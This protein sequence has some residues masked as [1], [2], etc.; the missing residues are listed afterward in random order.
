VQLVLE[1]ITKKDWKPFFDAYYW[2]TGL[3]EK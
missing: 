2:G 1:T 3:P